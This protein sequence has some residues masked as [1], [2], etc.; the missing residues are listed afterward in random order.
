MASEQTASIDNTTAPSRVFLD[1]LEARRE[2]IYLHVKAMPRSERAADFVFDLLTRLA[3]KGRLDAASISTFHSKSQHLEVPPSEFEV[4]LPDGITLSLE[5]CLTFGAPPPSTHEVLSALLAFGLN[6]YLK[7]KAPEERRSVIKRVVKLLPGVERLGPFVLTDFVDYCC[8]TQEATMFW[9]LYVDHVAKVIDQRTSK[10]AEDEE[11]PVWTLS[12]LME[13]DKDAPNALMGRR[14]ELLRRHIN[15]IIQCPQPS[16]RWRFA[17]VLI[18]KCYDQRLLHYV[19]TS[20]ALIEDEQV[21][22]KFLTRCH[23]KHISSALFMMQIGPANRDF[24]DEL[25]RYFEDQGLMDMGERVLDIYTQIHLIERPSRSI[26]VL[27]EALLNII[28]HKLES[29]PVDILLSWVKNNANAFRQC[30]LLI[31]LVQL[32]RNRLRPRDH[33]LLERVLQSFFHAFT[34]LGVRHPLNN[35][36]YHDCVVSAIVGLMRDEQSGHAA[37]IKSFTLNLPAEA[38]RWLPDEVDEPKRRL[39]LTYFMGLLAHVLRRAARRLYANGGTR[40]RALELYLMLIELFCQHPHEGTESGAYGPLLTLTQSLFPELLSQEYIDPP[41]PERLRELAELFAQIE[42]ELLSASYLDSLLDQWR[43]RN[44]GRAL[45][46]AVEEPEPEPEPAPALKRDSETGEQVIRAEINV[47]VP[48]TLKAP[49]VIIPR[50]QTDSGGTLRA[51]L[52]L[53]LLA[54]LGQQVLRIIGVKRLGDLIATPE[55]LIIRQ[56]H[57]GRGGEPLSQK[58]VTFPYSQVAE[59]SISQPLMSFHY[60]LG[61]LTLCTASL[62]GGYLL[63][64]GVRGA[65]HSL[66]FIGLS[67]LAFGLLF[68]LAANKRAQAAAR[69]VIIEVSRIGKTKSIAVAIDRSTEAGQAMINALTAR[70]ALKNEADFQQDWESLAT[71]YSLE[72][73]AAKE[74]EEQEEHLARE[75]EQQAIDDDQA[76]YQAEMADIE[77]PPVEK[78]FAPPVVEDPLDDDDEGEEPRVIVGGSSD[79]GFERLTSAPK[80]EQQPD[81]G[82]L[83]AGYESLSMPPPSLPPELDETPLPSDVGFDDAG[84]PTPALP[85]EEPSLPPPPAEEPPDE[86]Y[87][88]FSTAPTEFASG[89]DDVNS[90]LGLMVDETPPALGED[91]GNFDTILPSVPEGEDGN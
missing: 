63:F 52:G 33:Q 28:T 29:E 55:S 70:E 15:R 40:E 62:L 84:S 85:L 24:I 19:V 82:T 17:R 83:V 49:V 54:Y 46:E 43:D 27:R 87:P 31:D 47:H 11:P 57:Q 13:L 34:P 64:A 22:F 78:P 26:S 42:E 45:V 39:L 4:A 89:V 20:P 3:N 72:E 37:T 73:A 56:Q 1:A 69:R 50:K 80:Y 10:S 23:T 8:E 7:R 71:E 18:E 75:A 66:T 30:R 76:R 32:D 5:Q 86:P 9:Q 2:R 65:E 61:F 51:F 90:L 41:S 38:Q 58:E 21:L 53:D 59:L 12:A 6:Q 88:D 81:H 79:D 91:I 77:A 14:W 67:F 74:R 35:S 16:W 25:L 68:D 60:T 44:R 48:R 36:D